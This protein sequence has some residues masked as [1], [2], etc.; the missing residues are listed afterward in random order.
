MEGNKTCRRGV[1]TSWGRDGVGA[2][3]GLAPIDF[4]AATMGLIQQEGDMGDPQPWTDA[5][6]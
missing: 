1:G 6:T 5:G 2:P 3:A 4:S